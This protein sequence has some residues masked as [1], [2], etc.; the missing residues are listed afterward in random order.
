[1]SREFNFFP[2]H[3]TTEDEDTGLGH[4]QCTIRSYGWNEK[5]ESVYIKICDFLI[6]LW[7]ELP[8]NIEWTEDR[9]K[10]VCSKLLTLDKRRGYAPVRIELQMKQKLYYADVEK[11]G[12]K[13]IHK[14]YPYLQALFNSSDALKAFKYAVHL[15]KI[16]IISLGDII[17][18]CHGYDKQ[19]AP[20]FKFLAVTKCP[21]SNWIIAKGNPVKD[22]NKEST[23]IHEYVVSYKNITIH[24]MGEK[25]PTVYPSICSFDLEVYSS[26]SMISM[27]KKEIVDDKVIQIGMVFQKINY[28]T[29]EKIIK[30]Y[31]IHIGEISDIEDSIL[32]KCNNEPDM[33]R[34]FS[35]LLREED[36]DVVIG[37]NIF[38]FDIPYIQYRCSSQMYNIEDDVL[39]MSCIDNKLA[40]NVN[41][42]WESDA[43]GVQELNFWDVE[44]RLF[45]DLLPYVRRSEKLPNYR[46]ETVCDKYLKT[47]KDPIKP[48]DIFKSWKNKDWKLFTKVG[49]YCIQDCYVVLLL[50]EKMFIWWDL[51]E[52]ATVNN[53][54][55]L[56][57]YTKGQQI[58]MYSQVVKYTM[59]NNILLQSDGMKCDPDE[60]YQG[61]TVK[62]PIA[63][64]YKLIIPFD[65]ASLYPSIIQAIN[66][67][68]SKLVKEPAPHIDDNDCYVLE[69]DEHL[70][71]CCNKDPKYKVVHNSDNQVI[72]KHGKCKHYKFRFLKHEVSGNGVIPSILTGLLKARKDTRKIIAQYEDKIKLLKDQKLLLKTQDNIILIDKEINE[73]ESQC[74]ILDKRQLAFKVSANSL[75]GAMGTRT[76]SLPFVPGAQSVTYVGRISIEKASNFIRD[77]FN[78]LIVYNDTDSA[79]VSFPDMANSPI[80]EI[81]SFAHQV[82]DNVAKLFPSPMK[83]EFEDKIYYK[84]L[85]LT[86]KRYV[87]QMCDENGEINTKKLYTKG[88]VLQRRDNTPML[89]YCYQ[90]IIDF[91][92]KEFEFFTTVD[93]SLPTNQL[94]KYPL[95][96]H[97]HNILCDF[98]NKL[99]T[100]Q[101]TSKELVI[102]KGLTKTQYSEKSPPVQ[103]VLANKLENR[104]ITVPVNSRLEYV[105]IK[106]DYSLTYDKESEFTQGHKAEDIDYFNEFSNILRLDYLYYLDKQ[107]VN[108][109]SELLRVCLNL[110]VTRFELGNWSTKLKK[111]KFINPE[112]NKPEF[113]Y[114]L[115]K[116]IKRT[117][118]KTRTL[119]EDILEWRISKYNTCLEINKY[120]L[121]KLNFID[122][123]DI[124][125]LDTQHIINNKNILE[126]P[127]YIDAEL[128]SSG[129]MWYKRYK[130][131]EDGL[132]VGN[133]TMLLKYIVTDNIYC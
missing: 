34:K 107:L 95:V 61:A 123:N 102:T 68:Y 111:I 75:Y 76:G 101:F 117:K 90:Y 91:L 19:G 42:N 92:L 110:R 86:K 27:P 84:F 30:K 79:Y 10:K 97:W 105:F 99:M 103:K 100:R 8:E 109:M 48:I 66:I 64:F 16:N 80:K 5:N 98:V 82:V 22:S 120:S 38:G 59:Q 88:I 28:K 47:N 29:K 40:K 74:F 132:L 23:K 112:T 119:M 87:G 21:T 53:I 78:G 51:V 46:L 67:D 58:K 55:I 70:T 24:P 1:M 57:F 56:Y 122:N 54:P 44:G 3:W 17:F 6:P 31:L 113:K 121:S 69:W 62:E 32:I 71:N 85:I 13:Y 26:K 128:K 37:Y 89:K 14:K 11:R 108:P 20:F 131:I 60:K 49:K 127:L 7:I 129:R 93:K 83:L 15:K 36:P 81:W 25:L 118:D 125:S 9:L 73:L 12:D 39:R 65:F 77:N 96:Q 33:Y 106:T 130:L 45:I 52:S 72:S 50:F 4:K 116:L 126:S 104:G 43:Y 41:E 2:F 114:E 35:C 115:P 18:R 63:G 124:T 133:N 94:F